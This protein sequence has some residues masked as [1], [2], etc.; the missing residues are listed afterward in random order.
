MKAYRCPECGKIPVTSTIYTITTIG[1][2]SINV[3]HPNIIIAMWCWKRICRMYEKK[4]SKAGIRG[5][6]AAKKLK[7]KSDAM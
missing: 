4:L 2:C 3:T 7:E 5:A 1:C 6:E